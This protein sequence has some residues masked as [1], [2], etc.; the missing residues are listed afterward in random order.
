M[1]T[2][3][4][5]LSLTR[6]ASPAVVDPRRRLRWCLGVFTLL[7]AA[8]WCRALQ[9]EIGQGAT[10]REEALRAN[11]REKTLPAARGRILARDGTVLACDREVAAVAVQYR[12]LEEPPRQAWLEQQ[13]RKRLPSDQRRDAARLAVE[14]KKLRQE[15]D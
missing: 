11:R 10:F 15:R 7:L 5:E 6:A 14:V 9:L 2:D 3:W 12:Y 13:A 4:Q 8:I 1:P